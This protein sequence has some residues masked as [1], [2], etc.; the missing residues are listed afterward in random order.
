MTNKEKAL[1]LIGTF[2]TGDTTKVKELLADGYI[3]H[4]ISIADGLSGL[5]SV[6]AALA[7]QGI[8]MI[9]NET[10]FVLA[11]GDYVLAISEGTFGKRNITFRLRENRSLFRGRSG[12]KRLFEQNHCLH[13]GNCLTVCSMSAV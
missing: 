11:D 1:A 4:N 2:A 6:L 13:C 5:G 10:H 9:Y 8:Q 7:E 3:Q 12:N